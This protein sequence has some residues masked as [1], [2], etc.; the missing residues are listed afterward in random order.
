MNRVEPLPAL[1]GQP[2]RRP[3]VN[4]D[5][6]MDHHLQHHQPTESYS[7]AELICFSKK[8]LSALEFVQNYHKEMK[9]YYITGIIARILSILAYIWRIA[10]VDEGDDEEFIEAIAQLI[11]GVLVLIYE[12][13]LYCYNLKTYK[14][15]ISSDA[16]ERASG[17][18][19]CATNWGLCYSILGIIFIPLVTLQLIVEVNDMVGSD[20]GVGALIALVVA[21]IPFFILW[22]FSI[23]LTIKGYCN[24]RAIRE[25]LPG[26]GAGSGVEMGGGYR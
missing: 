23:D 12:I 11:A 15:S 24:Y 8:H 6:V 13:L 2:K 7:W 10:E 19:K 21:G 26:G 4:D 9:C 25:I 16:G 1:P 22:I 18:Y 14:A 5:P 20:E 3:E 17:P